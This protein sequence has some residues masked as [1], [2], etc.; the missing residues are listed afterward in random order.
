MKNMM[1]N[2]KYSA[3]ALK[4]LKVLEMQQVQMI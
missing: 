1:E 3:V 2:T 4:K